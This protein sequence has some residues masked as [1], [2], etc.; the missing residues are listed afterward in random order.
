MAAGDGWADW[1][2]EMLVMVFVVET[3]VCK[4]WAAVLLLHTEEVTEVEEAAIL[5]E[6][7]GGV[8]KEIHFW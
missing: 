1:V 8:C 6:L 4:D 3:V 2:D 5:Y 7:Y